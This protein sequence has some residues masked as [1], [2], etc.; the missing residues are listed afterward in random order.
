V[1]GLPHEA[2]Q[3]VA[4]AV[5]K[6]NYMH[7]NPCKGKWTL[8]TEP[9]EYKHSSAEYY[10]TGE[11]GIYEVLNYFELVDINLTVPLEKKAEST[12]HTKPGGETSARKR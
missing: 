3:V 8:A 4:L 1:I 5:L 10:L 9:V 2:G 7:D 12:P 11:Q 6:L